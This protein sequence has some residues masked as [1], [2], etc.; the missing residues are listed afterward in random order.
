M[1]K[2]LRF[3]QAIFGIFNAIVIVNSSP[4]LIFLLTEKGIAKSNDHGKT[5]KI[6]KTSSGDIFKSILFASPDNPKVI[7]VRND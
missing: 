5:F 7:F 6:V 4:N 1:K 2:V 3:L